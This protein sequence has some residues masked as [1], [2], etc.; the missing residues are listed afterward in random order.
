MF[1]IRDPELGSIRRSVTTSTRAWTSDSSG[2]GEIVTSV[3]IMPDSRFDINGSEQGFSHGPMESSRNF[4]PHSELRND[5]IELVQRESSGV[6]SGSSL[7]PTL[8]NGQIP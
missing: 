1:N 8:H 3:F 4:I 2:G 5:D 6:A 7:N